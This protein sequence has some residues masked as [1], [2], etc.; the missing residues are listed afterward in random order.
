MSHTPE[1]PFYIV[2]PYK[3]GSFSIPKM[4]LLKYGISL[5][6]YT[7]LLPVLYKFQSYIKLPTYVLFLIY[8]VYAVALFSFFGVVS[9]GYI[10]YTNFKTLSID[11]VTNEKQNVK[12][13]LKI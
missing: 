5:L 8:F 6:I 3:Y 1:R 10:V 12:K 11:I 4:N 9:I 2:G 7:A 13:Y